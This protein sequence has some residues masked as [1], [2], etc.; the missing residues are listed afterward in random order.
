[1][2]A[3]MA[4]QVTNLSILQ[5]AS[6]LLGGVTEKRQ[7]DEEAKSL[8]RIAKVEADNVRRVNRKIHGAQINA[9]RGDST[10]GSIMD[11]QAEAAAFGEL[12]A[13][14]TR[15]GFKSRAAQREAQ[16]R[17]A[18]VGSVVKGAGTILGAELIK[19]SQ[20]PVPLSGDG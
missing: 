17:Q 5:A 15:F 18:L 11:L 2:S 13:L 14:R 7:A 10:T 9:F 8:K 4:G 16:G 19:L 6:G 3:G 1:M 20:D 12:N